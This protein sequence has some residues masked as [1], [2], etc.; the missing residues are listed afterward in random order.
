MD[1]GLCAVEMLYKGDDASFVEKLMF[2]LRS[3]IFNRYPNAFVEEGEFPKPLGEN[4]KT[5]VD[6]LEDLRVGT[7]GNSRSPLFGFSDFFERRLNRKS[8]R[9]NSSHDQISYAV[10]CLKKKEKYRFQ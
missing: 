9:L 1:R 4:V 3:L 8:T 5:K 6:R 7:K 10:F 2:L